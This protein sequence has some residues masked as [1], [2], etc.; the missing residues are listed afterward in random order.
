[1]NGGSGRHDADDTRQTIE[2]AMQAAA[3][4]HRIFVIEDVSQI[5]A[6][7]QQAVD[8]AKEQGAVV[9]A[10]GGDGTINA[11]ANTV[12]GSGCLFGAIPQGT[13]NY[14]GRTHGIPE[15]ISES[16][17]DLLHGAPVPVQVGQVNDH[18]FL[19][20]AS[21]GLYPELLEDREA[22]KQKY[23]RSRLVAIWAAI[24][25]VFGRHRQLHMTLEQDG[26]RV[27]MRTT[28]LFIGNNRLQL[29]QVGMPQAAAV[30]Q[31]QLAAIAVRPV[32]KLSM[33][34]L[35][36]CGALG[37]LGDAEHVV[38]F[39]FRELTV[40]PRRKS[41]G[42][43]EEVSTDRKNT[44][45]RTHRN[46]IKVAADGEI[47]WLRTPLEFRVASEPLQLIK[48]QRTSKE[49]DAQSD[50]AVSDEAM[51]DNKSDSEVELGGHAA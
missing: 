8:A 14:F 3:R 21:V 28:T 22:F 46:Q 25:T 32:G 43:V 39:S 49:N 44:G 45:K 51:L 17:Q 10:V 9:V 26:K 40:A 34:W 5:Q 38:G 24:A 37:R 29:D 18:I 4:T 6:T 31:G 11:V 13:F 16:L 33:L 42:T 23:G 27:A 35:G 12:L 2:A 41:N 36:V 7:V 15:E 19:V 48:R 50:A 1:M 30:V 47:M 20:N